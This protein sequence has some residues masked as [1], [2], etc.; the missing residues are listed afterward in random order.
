M[1][2]LALAISA[3][4]PSMFTRFSLALAVKFESVARTVVAC[5]PN[6]AVLA[7]GAARPATP[8]PVVDAT[9]LAVGLPPNR[10]PTVEAKLVN[11]EL[12]PAPPP[13]PPPRKPPN[14]LPMVPKAPSMLGKFVVRLPNPKPAVAL[15]VDPGS[16]GI[17]SLARI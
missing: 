4:A 1:F 15:S 3:F 16:C 7:A 5:L 8:A 2:A 11:S 12:T 13:V 14:K 6:S 17:P 10:P 9:V